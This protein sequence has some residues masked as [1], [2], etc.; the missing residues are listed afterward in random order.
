MRFLPKNNDALNAYTGL[1]YPNH[2]PQIR[3]L[4][5][6]LQKRYCAYSE[7]KF[8]PLDSPDIEH[9][10]PRLK[11]TTQDTIEN[12]HLVLHLLNNRK[13]RTI[14]GFLPLPNPNDPSI[15]Q[16]IKYEDG[17]FVPTNEDDVEVENLIRWIGANR[18]EVWR[19]RAAAVAILRDL[20]SH[21]SKDWLKQQICTHPKYQSFP[22]AIEA[23]LG[24]PIL[25]WIEENP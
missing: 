10:D 9:F 20:S 22:T 3:S 6:D 11:G 12:W 23:E 17:D 8:L 25:Q 14:E 24:L 13:S 5:A 7:K 4:L 21:V 2:R 18:E 1:V 16:R 19:E 15:G